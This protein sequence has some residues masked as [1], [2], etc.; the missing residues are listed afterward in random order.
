MKKKKVI[1]IAFWI[2]ILVAS[3]FI[4]FKLKGWSIEGLIKGN[5]SVDNIVKFETVKEYPKNE[6]AGYMHELANGL[7]IAKDD[8]IWGEREMNKENIAT[9]LKMAKSLPKSEQTDN[10][11][12]IIKTWQKGDFS[13]IV[14]DHN[15]VWTFLDGGVGRAVNVKIKKVEEAQKRLK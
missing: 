10:W 3:T 6:V 9:V 14:N 15:T 2:F 8:E 12:A 11:I 7:I 5:M 4:L 13:N 1:N